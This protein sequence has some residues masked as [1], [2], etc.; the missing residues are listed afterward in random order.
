MST[1]LD[2]STSGETV[3]QSE[4]ERLL[5]EMSGANA[6][7]AEA[8]ATD[9][10]GG[11]ADGTNRRHEFPRLS[12]FSSRELR[13]LRVRHEEFISS[14]A[15]KLT[16]HLGVE[17]G[18]QMSMLDTLP[19]Q[20]FI[21]GLA[22][23]T[24]LTLVKLEPLLGICLLD[25]PPRLG[26]SIANRELGG[27]AVSQDDPR[28]LGK[29]EARLVA[30]VVEMIVG[31]WCGIWS[32]FQS[33]RPVLLGN[34]NNGRFL[35]TCGP[36]TTMLV[37]GIATQLNGVSEQ[38]Q[39]A[40]PHFTLEPL[41]Q[42]SSATE[43]KQTKPTAGALASK[44]PWKPSLNGVPVSVTARLPE[45]ELTVRELAEFKPG[46]ILPLPPQ[47]VTQVRLC[48]ADTETFV[49]GLGVSED[50]WAVMLSEVIKS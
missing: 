20:K 17:V 45:V 46:D 23:P 28:E 5:A 3:T 50:R 33:M 49:G 1:P 36:D 19:F 43:E 27:P 9:R 38:I 31:E 10:P 39:F 44:Q 34:E 47:F 4:V 8:G 29:I 35:Q 32:E 48:V 18:M 40:F 37:L 12:F 13:K 7:E 30:R 6:A 21:D 14:L 22:N 41:I 2:K 24:H 16:I 42:Q 25:I 15:A 11:L 26:I